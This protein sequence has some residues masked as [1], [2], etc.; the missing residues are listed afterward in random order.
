MYASFFFYPTAYAKNLSAAK[1]VHINMAIMMLPWNWLI[2]W[3]V[4]MK[5][6]VLVNVF[7]C[8]LLKGVPVYTYIMNCFGAPFTLYKLWKWAC[9]YKINEIIFSQ[10]IVLSYVF[11]TVVIL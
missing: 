1:K 4:S 9:P 5:K 2:V 10:A 6:V 7:L 3:L 11:D 8:L